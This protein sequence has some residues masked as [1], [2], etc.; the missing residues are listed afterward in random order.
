MEE[1]L[2]H[3]MGYT[4]GI[5]DNIFRWHFVL[6]IDISMIFRGHMHIIITHCQVGIN[7]VFLEVILKLYDVCFMKNIFIVS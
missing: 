1:S 7:V 6:E 5:F 4:P 3:N 2:S